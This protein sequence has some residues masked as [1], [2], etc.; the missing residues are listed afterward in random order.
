MLLRFK[1]KPSLVVYGLLCHP[2]K[3]F[4]VYNTFLISL[5]EFLFY[6]IQ[7]GVNVKTLSKNF[8]FSGIE[9]LILL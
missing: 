5:Q 2:E 4:I 6:R 3:L 7:R 1:W 9:Q 8:A